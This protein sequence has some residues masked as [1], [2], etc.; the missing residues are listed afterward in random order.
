MKKIALIAALCIGTVGCQ[1]QTPPADSVPVESLPAAAAAAAAAPVDATLSVEPGHVTSCKN[2]DRTVAVVKWQVTK[3]GVET[4][5]VE[6]D[7]A[8]DP[9]RKTFT[10]GGA[11]GE[12]T[13][14]DW[15]GA[16][17]RFHL[18]DSASKEELATHV[19]E[20]KPCPTPGG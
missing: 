3:P 9:A 13:T 10:M 17:V 1:Q 11:T 18:I 16:G 2:G 7:S 15:V 5:R 12:A 19:V 8:T 20:M 6:V 4:V 14:G